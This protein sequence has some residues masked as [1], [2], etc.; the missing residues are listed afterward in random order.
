MNVFLVGELRTY[1]SI[2]DGSVK[3]TSTTKYVL[4]PKVDKKKDWEVKAREGYFIMYSKTRAGYRVL[5]GDTVVTSVHVLFN[6][7]VPERSSSTP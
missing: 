3:P 2:D 4:V 6:E 7:S 5:L 1:P